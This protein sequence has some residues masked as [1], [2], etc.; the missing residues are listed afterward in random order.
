MNKGKKREK[1]KGFNRLPT[2]SVDCHR[3]I[4][5]EDTHSSEHKKCI[6]LYSIIFAIPKAENEQ[7]GSYKG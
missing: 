5:D 7:A 1:R 6:H 3:K 4:I 2:T